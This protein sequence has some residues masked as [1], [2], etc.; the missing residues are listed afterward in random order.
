MQVA[1]IKRLHA[2]AALLRSELSKLEEQLDE[3][4]SHRDFLMR[5]TPPDFFTTVSA[6]IQ[7]C[8]HTFHADPACKMQTVMMLT[9]CRRRQLGQQQPMPAWQPG[10]PSVMSYANAGT[11]EGHAYMPGTCDPAH[12][13]K[14]HW[15]CTPWLQV[16]AFTAYLSKLHKCGQLSI[17]GVV[18]L[19]GQMQGKQKPLLGRH[20]MMR[21]RS[22]KPRLQKQPS[23]R[24]WQ[25]WLQLRLLKSHPSQWRSQ[26]T[27]TSCRCSSRHAIPA[28]QLL[29][30]SMALRA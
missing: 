3:C 1:E 2:A 29:K 28:P 25:L 20:T 14:I 5:I 10:S 24:L 16:S 18:S 22:R 12:H 8:L 11:T 7:P 17:V 23:R 15:A 13:H 19:A 26:L 4:R 6:C 27:Q 9:A 21:A 30:D